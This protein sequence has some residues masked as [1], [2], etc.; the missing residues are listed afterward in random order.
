MGRALAG[1]AEL[2]RWLW[3]V[4]KKWIWLFG[5]LPAALDIASTYVPGFPQVQI[6]LE[7]SIGAGCLGVFVS[8]FLVHLDV[9]VQLAAY[10]YQEPE[11]DMQVL[12]VS[13]KVCSENTIHIDATF[14]ITRKN[15]WPGMLVEITLVDSELP[16]GVGVGQISR[17]SYQPVDWHCYNPLK[18]P[19]TIP[20]VGCDF[21]ITA[22]CPVVK[23]PDQPDKKQWEEAVIRLGLLIG[24]KT[25]PVGYV[26]K[27]VPLSIPVNLGQVFDKFA[28]SG[29]EESV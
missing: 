3:L 5:L 22:H 20:S 11:Y 13:S 29:I 16:N 8:A 21:G 19:Y 17:M 24:Y 14:R 15:P 27:S 10:E 26:Q 9:K 2:L 7:W 28:I 1:L 6:P 25:Q 18:L 4:V 23:S 12:E